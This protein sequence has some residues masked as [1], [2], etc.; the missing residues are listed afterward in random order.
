MKIVCL[1]GGP[2]E[3]GNSYTIAGRPCDAA[4]GLG[5]E[6]RT[7]DLD[8]SRLSRMPGMRGVQDQAR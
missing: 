8:E 3:D 5:A 2:R 4:R 6:V 7:F 1:P